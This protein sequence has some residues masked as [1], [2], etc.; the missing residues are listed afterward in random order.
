MCSYDL[1]G[2]IDGKKLLVMHEKLAK[3]E[4]AFFPHLIN[5]NHWIL[6]S[7]SGKDGTIV[8]YDS[9]NALKEEDKR[10]I[11]TACGPI[12]KEVG[13]NDVPVKS[14]LINLKFSIKLNFPGFVV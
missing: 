13:F 11:F 3:C 9:L 5:K 2:I 10:T 12:V 1:Q 8:I 4:E 7:V 14:N 6:V